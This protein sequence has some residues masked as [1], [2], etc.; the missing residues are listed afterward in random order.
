M[1]S[2]ISIFLFIS[3]ALF[4]SGEPVYN[5]TCILLELYVITEFLIYLFIIALQHH[6]LYNI[7]ELAIISY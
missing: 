7:T 3:S 4:V 1:K 5:L 2:W 6:T